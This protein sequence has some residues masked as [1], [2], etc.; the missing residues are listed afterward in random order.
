MA[1]KD[2]ITPKL[3]RFRNGSGY[4]MRISLAESLF[5]TQ[6]PI[7][8]LKNPKK[9]ITV[10]VFVI[11]VVAFF[12][13]AMLLSKSVIR[14]G[15]IFGWIMFTVGYFGC[16]MTLMTRTDTLE[17]KTSYVLP[18]LRYWRKGGRNVDTGLLA[19]GAPF[20]QLL[21]IDGTVGIKED[22]MIPFLN[23]EI[24]YILAVVG[25]ASR[26]T[27]ED[28]QEMIIKDA[29]DIY[30]QMP[31]RIGM[32]V[33]TQ[34]ALQD[35]SVQLQCKR[36]QLDNLK[37]FGITSPGLRQ[38]VKRQGLTLRDNVGSNF[39]MT[40]QYILIRGDRGDVETFLRILLNTANSNNDVFLKS[41]RLLRNEKLRVGRDGIPLNDPKECEKVIGSI[42]NYK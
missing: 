25:N 18:I 16:F 35:V 22:G 21:D 27:F 33:I 32:T 34:T 1:D 5:D 15:G 42:I 11:T 31:P 17:Y 19:P 20:K 3:S 40:K 24:G 37:E 6:F 4:A 36:R 41:A 14:F 10:R 26:M 8:V 23:G 9:P 7:S 39:S 30:R 28:D 2:E 12:A 38:I 29:R 13:F